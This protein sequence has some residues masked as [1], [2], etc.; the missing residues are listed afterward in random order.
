MARPNT[1]GGGTATSSSADLCLLRGG[2]QSCAEARRVA[3]SRRA[4]DLRTRRAWD[5]KTP[6]FS[7]NAFFMYFRPRDEAARAPAKPVLPNSSISAV[8]RPRSHFAAHRVCPQHSARAKRRGTMNQPSRAEK[9]VLPEGV[10]KLTFTRDTK[11][12]N[13]GTFIVQKEDH[14][15]GNTVRMQ[16]HRDPNVVFAGYQVPHPSDNRIVVKVR[17]G[18]SRCARSLSPRRAHRDASPPERVRSISSGCVTF[19]VSSLASRVHRRRLTRVPRHQPAG[20][21]QQGLLSHAGDDGSGGPPA[22]GGTTRD[23]NGARMITLH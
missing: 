6:P 12:S 23:G 22:D 16:L 11:V 14:T 3:H 17:A 4:S 1:E 21:H 9:F 7:R 20:P 13:A 5:W 8:E 2:I 10:R 15:L 19:R 18:S